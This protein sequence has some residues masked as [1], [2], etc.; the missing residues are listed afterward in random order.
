MKG[1]R[2]WDA[3]VKSWGLLS[4]DNIDPT[5]VGAETFLN[6]SLI[7]SV[8]TLQL[9]WREWGQELRDRCLQSFEW[10]GQGPAGLEW[11]GEMLRR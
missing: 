4:I 7:V 1:W 5:N 2:V 6:V 8:G 9:P 3:T 10:E 11:E